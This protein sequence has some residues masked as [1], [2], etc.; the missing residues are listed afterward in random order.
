[1]VSRKAA[2]LLIDLHK[3][4]DPGYRTWLGEVELLIDLHK[5]QDPGYPHGWEKLH[6]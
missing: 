4:Q 5:M 2:G 3:M 1:M 6:Y